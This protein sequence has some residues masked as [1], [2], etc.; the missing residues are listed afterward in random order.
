MRWKK[1]DPNKELRE[2]IRG[3]LEIMYY[4]PEVYEK[5]DGRL[6]SDPF[7]MIDG[8]P[9]E[10]LTIALGL[11]HARLFN[12][13]IE[14]EWKMSLEIENKAYIAPNLKRIVLYTVHDLFVDL[15]P[16]LKTYSEISAKV[17][18]ILMAYIDNPISE[19]HKDQGIP[20]FLWKHMISISKQFSFIIDIYFAR[21]SPYWSMTK[22]LNRFFNKV[23]KEL[24]IDSGFRRLKDLED[25]EKK[26]L[27]PE[28]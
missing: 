24:K 19:E 25:F 8:R 27:P 5:Q 18:S 11:T 10:E 1:I 26:Q 14:N 22:Q 17:N 6:I 4:Y 3:T 20:D 23:H 7:E 12:E 21:R 15:E 13:M 16:Y 28:D 9:P 2:L